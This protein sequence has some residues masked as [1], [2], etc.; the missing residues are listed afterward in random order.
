MP[1][2]SKCLNEQC[3]LSKSCYRFLCEPSEWQSYS[4][5]KP[6]EDGTCEHYDFI[7]NYRRNNERLPD[8]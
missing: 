6:N 5:F 1:D 8:M 3:N 7:G 2:I 4:D